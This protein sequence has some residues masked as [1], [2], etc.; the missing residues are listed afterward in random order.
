VAQKL[1]FCLDQKYRDLA[2]RWSYA[3]TTHCPEGLA[4]KNLPNI[5]GTRAQKMA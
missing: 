5:P 1:Y 4:P 3:D 2:D